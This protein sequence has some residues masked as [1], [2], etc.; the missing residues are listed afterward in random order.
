M[1]ETELTPSQLLD[2]EMLYEWKLKTKTTMPD[3]GSKIRIKMDGEWGEELE[4]VVRVTGR[5]A[6]ILCKKEGVID[7]AYGLMVVDT[8]D[9]EFTIWTDRFISKA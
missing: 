2:Q 5:G 9:V 6:T 4:S 3:I 8:A 7:I 1:A